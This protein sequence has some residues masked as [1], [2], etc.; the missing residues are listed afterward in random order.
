MKD[1]YQRMCWRPVWSLDKEQQSDTNRKLYQWSRSRNFT[2]RVQCRQMSTYCWQEFNDYNK[3]SLQDWGLAESTRARIE[4]LE[5]MWIC[6]YL[7]NRS[8]YF[9]FEICACRFYLRDKSNGRYLATSPDDDVLLFLRLF[10]LFEPFYVTSTLQITNQRVSC[11][12]TMQ[13][14][15]NQLISIP[16]VRRH[17]RHLCT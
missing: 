9:D 15:H 13:K 16:V 5:R 3:I 6:F 10:K 1:F 8:V 4:I 11:I 7:E 2:A 14:S 17:I 12:K